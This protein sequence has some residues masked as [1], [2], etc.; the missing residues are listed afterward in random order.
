[1]TMDKEKYITP[2][3]EV[4]E[5]DTEDVITASTES[6]EDETINIPNV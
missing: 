2:E 1:M 4:I 6:E 3:M 5:F